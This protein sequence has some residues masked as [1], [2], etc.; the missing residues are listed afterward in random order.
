MAN[1]SPQQIAAYAYRAGFRGTDLLNAVA[2]AMRESNGNP[3]AYNPESAAGTKPGSGSRGLWQIYGSAH[4]Q[5]NN[6][7]VYDPMKN[8]EAAYQVYRE[9]GNKF[10]PW[11]T[12]NN[13]SAKSLALS[14]GGISESASAGVASTLTG[15]GSEIV[16]TGAAGVGVVTGGV[17]SVAGSV[18]GSLTEAANGILDGIGERILGKNAEGKPR[19]VADLV[20]FLGGVTLILLGIIFLFVKS[21]VAKET[22]TAV[23]KAAPVP[24]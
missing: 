18:A 24:L 20:A 7:S 11:S 22:V 13:G 10:T 6:D 19:E 14:L 3:T 1:L 5:Y 16:S 15:A 12:W 23:T 17:G 21:G 2:I 8:A 9:A 4:P